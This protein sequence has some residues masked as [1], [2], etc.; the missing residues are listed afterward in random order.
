[1][2]VLFAL[3][4]VTGKDLGPTTDAWVQLYP[5][6]NAEAEGARLVA[7]LR[8]TKPELREQLLANY[9]D[10]KPEHHTEGLANAIPLIKGPLQEKTRTA[11]VVRLSRQKPDELRARLA[12][13]DDEMRHAAALACIRKADPDMLSDLIAL[14]LDPDV[15]IAEGAHK[16]LT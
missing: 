3:R 9:R 5:H 16:V 15:D 11:L 2:A 1:E 12:D 14:L 10:A 4:A 7:A 6:A 13:D 8:R